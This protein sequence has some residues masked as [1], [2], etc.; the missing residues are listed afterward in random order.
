V[1]FSKP[2]IVAK[3]PSPPHSVNPSP[4]VDQLL[5]SETHLHIAAKTG[6]LEVARLLLEAGANPSVVCVDDEKTAFHVAAQKRDLKMMELLLDHGAPIGADTLFYAS[7]IAHL[8]MVKLVLARGAN[9]A[10]SIGNLGH[11]LGCAVR[12]GRRHSPNLEVVKYLLDLGAD[13]SVTLSP[14]PAVYLDGGPPPPHRTDLLYIAMDFRHPTG[15][16]PMEQLIRKRLLK[17]QPAKWEGVP[18]SEAKKELMGTLLSHGVGKDAAMATIS[19]HLAALAKEAEQVPGCCQGN[20][21]GGGGRHSRCV[22]PFEVGATSS[23]G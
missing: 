11:A 9:N 2:H 20:D 13:T 12:G 3:L 10:E 6:N 7:T 5:F 22:G 8:D 1:T 14:Y 16:G 4:G 15:S 18:L 17:G 21:K 23:P 19:A